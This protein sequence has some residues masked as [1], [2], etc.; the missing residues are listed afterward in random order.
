MNNDRSNI[1][2]IVMQRVHLIR[3][4]RFAISSGVFSTLVFI[5]ALWGIGR[6]VWVAQVLQ[7]APAHPIDILRFYIA[8]F[9]HTRL[10]VQALVVLALAA[11]AYV[12]REIVRAI[13][14]VSAAERV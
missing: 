7:N 11:L 9:L 13:A 10:P 8:A 1:E 4:L 5:L 6:E 2:R 14:F 12:A 3:A